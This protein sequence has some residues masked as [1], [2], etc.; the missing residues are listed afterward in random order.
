MPESTQRA[1]DQHAPACSA[2]GDLALAIFQVAC[3]MTRSTDVVDGMRRR[4]NPE[5]FEITEPY[6][7][8]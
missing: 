2:A 3:V 6:Q 5:C 7:A 8:Q 1:R 4:Q